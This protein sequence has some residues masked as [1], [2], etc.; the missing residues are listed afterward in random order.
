MSPLDF[1]AVWTGG[2]DADR[3]RQPRF[4]T[5]IA[6]VFFSLSSH[7]S[8]AISLSPPPAAAEEAYCVR[9]A[10]SI[11]TKGA[12]C[13]SGNTNYRGDTDSTINLDCSGLKNKV[14]CGGGGVF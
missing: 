12:A 7:D 13:D 1:V 14:S 11:Q 6:G 8:P 2:G 3:A 4:L 9:A 5:P 10:R